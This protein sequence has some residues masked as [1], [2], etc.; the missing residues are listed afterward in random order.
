MAAAVVVVQG[1]G[2]RS[3]LKLFFFSSPSRS[4]RA[5]L[6]K[7]QGEEVEGAGIALPV[8]GLTVPPRERG[9]RRGGGGRGFQGRL[10]GG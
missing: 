4:C 10:R 7:A 9:L 6:Q 8:W 1:R 2:G 3:G 5:R